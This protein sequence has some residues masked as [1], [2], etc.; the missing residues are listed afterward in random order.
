MIDD[1]AIKQKSQSRLRLRLQLKLI[2]AYFFA[3]LT[4]AQRALAAALIFAL[5]AALITNFFFAGL[6]TT[7]TLAGVAAGLTADFAAL[8]LAQ[9][10]F[11]AAATLALPAA[12][13]PPFFFGALPTTGA[14]TG[15]A[16]EPSNWLSSFSKSAIFSWRAA[17]WRNCWADRLAIELI[18]V[19]LSHFIGNSQWL[20]GRVRQI[21]TQVFA[22]CPDISTN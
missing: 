6:A 5:A 20:A 9:R 1:C 12:L 4:F 19:L 7:A 21:I 13:M 16:D 8:I 10:A 3:A 17:A 2:R 15:V 22:G 11:C 14:A 18:V